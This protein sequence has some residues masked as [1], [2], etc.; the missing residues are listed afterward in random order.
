MRLVK[1]FL[2]LVG[3]LAAIGATPA[4]A[5]LELT[6]YSYDP[7]SKFGG[8]S[9]ESLGHRQG[10]SA[11]RFL[12]YAR[13][14]VTFASSTLYAFCIDVTTDLFTYSPYTDS[15][16]IPGFSDPDKRAQ[17]AAILFNSGA[18]LD[19]ALTQDDK[20]AAS[21]ALQL[22]VWEVMYE[23]GLSGYTVASGN[24]SVYYDFDPYIGLADSYL[25][26]VESGLWTGNASTLRALVSDTGTSQNLVYQTAPVPEPAAWALMLLGFGAI[27]SA[28]RRRHTQT[29]LPA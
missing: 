7:G 19:A 8:I 25:A 28:L 23:T 20:D 10:G 24:F 5:T 13:D 27:G 15:T 4:N 14:S 29:A 6:G 22:A 9:V 1:R 3:L 26:N 17:L 18:T 12:L 21:A 16:T 11:G 2:P